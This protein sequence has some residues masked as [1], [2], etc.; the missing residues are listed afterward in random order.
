MR[1]GKKNIDNG[2][3]FGALFTG[4]SKVFGCLSHELLIAKLD[5]Y[6][7]DKNALKLVNSYL[8]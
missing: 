3:A 4:L 5:G 2:G 1:N 6:G 7:F 8:K